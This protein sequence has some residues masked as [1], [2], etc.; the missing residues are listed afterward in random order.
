ML[1]R[2]DIVRTEALLMRSYG[3][4]LSDQYWIRPAGSGL[5]WADVNFF[6]NGFSDDMGD[7]LFGK[8]VWQG[9][10]DLTSPDNASDGLLMKRWKIIGGKRYLMKSGTMPFMQEPFNE[11]MAS[12]IADSLGMPHI[13][14]GI[15]EHEGA[16]C[17]ICE[18]FITRTRSSCP[19]TRSCVPRSMSQ[20]YPC[21]ITMS[22]A[23]AVTAWTWSR[24][25]T[26]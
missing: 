26:G 6:D 10:L 8:E 25:S 14:Y 21:T 12:I 15:V 20:A 2:L 17:S 19:R 23:A 1:E 9:L 24:C 5:D 16:V 11:V 18:D 3:L 7:L 22:H 4:S 13:D